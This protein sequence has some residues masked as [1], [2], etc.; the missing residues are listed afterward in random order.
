MNLSYHIQVGATK[1]SPTSPIIERS[2]FFV[3][4]FL[5]EKQGLESISQI[6]RAGHRP[7]ETWQDSDFS[8][9]VRNQT[10]I[11]DGY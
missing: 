7:L 10:T 5:Q 11:S 8:K 2:K 3:R 1:L 6:P 9:N 4:N